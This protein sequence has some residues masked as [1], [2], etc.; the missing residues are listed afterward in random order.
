MFMLLWQS[1]KGR[2]TSLYYG[3]EIHSYTMLTRRFWLF[4]NITFTLEMSNKTILIN[5]FTFI[6]L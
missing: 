5:E 4:Y 3:E 1:Y 2:L 6:V